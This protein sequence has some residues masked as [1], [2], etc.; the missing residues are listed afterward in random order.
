MSEQVYVIGTTDGK[1]VK[2][3]VSGS[4]SRRLRQIQLMSP[5]PVKLFWSGPGGRATEQA[6]HGLFA[7][8]RLHGEWFSFDGLDAAAAVSSAVL[9]LAPPQE[10]NEPAKARPVHTAVAATDT[11]VTFVSGAALLSGLGIVDNI[12]PDGVRYVAR[13]AP[14][15]P[16]GDQEGQ[17]PYLAVGKTRTM[18]KEV[19]LAF[20][21]DGPKRGGRGR[22]PSQRKRGEAP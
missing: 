12:T 11:H 6:L 18:D 13:T 9:A 20:F 21:N 16:F 2:I 22:I 8:R 1:I 19:F 17:I 4:V 15:W 7:D 3:G 14:E 10:R 5:V